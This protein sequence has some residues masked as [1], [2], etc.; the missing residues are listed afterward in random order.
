M[1]FCPKCGSLMLPTKSGKTVTCPKCGARTKTAKDNVVIK[2]K[3]KKEKL[4]KR[5]RRP[6]EIIDTF[7]TV[8]AVCG[9]C[10]N[11][12]AYWW[13]EQVTSALGGAEDLP[14]TQFFRCT[15]C[16]YTWRKTA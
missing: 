8:D 11:T 1:E 6:K 5:K 13:T 9:K 4:E 10:G 14:E 2:E 3:R 15:K 16:S 12:K 7:P